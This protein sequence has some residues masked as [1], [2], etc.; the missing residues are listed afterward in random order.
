MLYEKFAQP[1]RSSTAM[2]DIDMHMKSGTTWGSY[3][4][5]GGP[6]AP[7]TALQKKDDE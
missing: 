2:Y 6:G 3:F 5:G 4:Y 7:S 1:I